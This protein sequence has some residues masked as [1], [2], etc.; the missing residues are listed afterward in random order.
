[1]RRVRWESGSV[2]VEIIAPTG[3]QIYQ[4]DRAIVTVP[5]GVLRASPAE[6]GA[7]TFEPPITEKLS[8]MKKI[9]P[10][11]VMKVVAQFRSPFWQ[12]LLPEGRRELGFAL[13]LEASFSTW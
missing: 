1:V 10:G 8:A 3:G 4:A 12:S 7:I 13:C 2:T 5:I 6:Q 11:H 9:A